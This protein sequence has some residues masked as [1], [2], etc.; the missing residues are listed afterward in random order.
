MAEEPERKRR[1]KNLIVHGKHEQTSHDDKEFIN[2]LIKDLQVGA[3]NVKQIERLGHINGN[4][5]RPIKLVFNNEGDKEKVF[6]NLRNLKG[7]NYY[8]WVSITEDYTYNERLLI[9]KFVEQAN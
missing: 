2:Q 8:Q 1:G 6:H 4:N 7:K 9:K 5:G 3:I